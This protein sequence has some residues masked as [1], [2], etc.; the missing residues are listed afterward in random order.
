MLVESEYSG[1]LQFVLLT[2]LP[3]VTCS[4]F[5]FVKSNSLRLFLCWLISRR[6]KRE[7]GTPTNWYL[8]WVCLASWG[9][10]IRA[11]T[12]PFLRELDWVRGVGGHTQNSALPL[13]WNPELRVTYMHP[14]PMCI[15]G[16]FS[17]P[18][19][20]DWGISEHYH[21]RVRR[22]ASD[23]SLPVGPADVPGLTWAACL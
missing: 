18:S 13:V 15:R 23:H 7:W 4:S 9:A 2:F 20:P 22:H 14:S 8:T 16:P 3:E 5:V 1:K 6:K 17:S 10:G 11:R 12:F 19:V 21:V